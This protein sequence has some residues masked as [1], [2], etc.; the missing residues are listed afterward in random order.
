M[1]QFEVK[2]AG[3]IPEIYMYAGIGEAYGGVSAESFVKAVNNIRGKSEIVVHLHS[4]GGDAF[5]AAGM[6]AALKRHPAHVIMQVDGLAASS[7]SYLMMAGDEIQIA[8]NGIVM[9]HE[10]ESGAR[11][12]ASEMERRAAMLRTL[13]GTVAQA[14]SERSGQS[15]DA[16]ARMMEAETWMDARTAVSNG[17]ADKLLPSKKVSMNVDWSRFRNPPPRLVIG[18]GEASKE[19]RRRLD[20]LTP[21]GKTK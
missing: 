4:E 6:Y 5:E 16:I 1:N 7:A 3:P 19:Y 2:M 21:S 18:E 8:D 14:Y 12:R 9:I 13:I 20:E 17:F 15:D 10:P 11:G